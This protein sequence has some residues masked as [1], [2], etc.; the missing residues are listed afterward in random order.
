MHFAILGQTAVSAVKDVNLSAAQRRAVAALVAAGSQGMPADRLMGAI[1]EDD[2]DHTGPLKTLL[3][4]LR[5]LLG[6]RLPK[7]SAGSYRLDLDD[8]DTVDVTIFRALVEEAKAALEAGQR[9]RSV[10]ALQQALGLWGDP[11]LADVSTNVDRLNQWR[12]D[13]LLERQRA[14]LTLLQ[15]RL[16]LGEHHSLV[17]DVQRALSED[18]LSEPLY[19]ILMTA[20]FRAGRRAQALEQFEI[21]SATLF[22]HTGYGPGKDLQRLSEQIAADTPPAVTASPPA[23]A[24]AADTMAYPPAQLPAGVVDFTGR[25]QEIADLTAF[26]R[27]DGERPGVPIAVISGPPG[28]GKTELAIHVGHRLR[29]YFPCGQI[30]VNMAAMSDQPPVIAD[31]LAELLSMLGVAPR[32]LPPSTAQ[33]SSLVRSLLARRRML[34]VLDDVAAVH[35]VQPLF[36][37]AAGSAVILTS[38]IRLAGNGIR[39][40]RLEPLSAD[41]AR[42]LLTQIIGSERVAAEPE[43]T[44]E[45]LE[46]CSGLPLA[47]R[48]AGARLSI[49]DQ[50]RISHLAKRLSNRLPELTVDGW[51]VSA[52]VADSYH[53]LPDDARQAFRILSLAGPGDW[54]IWLATMLLGVDD[55]EPVL[56]T[57]VVHSLLTPTGVDALGQPRYR[58]HDLLREYGAMRL[59]EHERSTERDVT[60]ERLIMGWLELTDAADANVTRE[61]YFSPLR[62]MRGTFAPEQSFT[63]ISDD[64]DGWFAT[65]I[66]NVLSVIR[67]ASQQ[68]RHRLAY[69]LAMRASSYLVREERITDAEDMWRDVIQA[70]VAVSDVGIIANA[71]LR[72]ASLIIRQHGGPQRALPLMDTCITSLAQQSDRR[73]LAR[74]LA[75]RAACRY[76]IALEEQDAANEHETSYNP[77][78][79]LAA[80]DAQ[81]SLTLARMLTSSHAELISLRT[82]ALVASLRG[83]HDEA[84]S[85]GQ[86]AMAVSKT[87]CVE[88]GDGGYELFVLQALVTVLWAA[89]QCSRALQECERG[90]TLAQA[91][92][93]RLAEA[94]FLEQAGD[95]LTTMGHGTEALTHYHRAS[96]MYIGE[97]ADQHRLRCWN[98]L[99]AADVATR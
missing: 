46:V 7:G 61:P 68:Q 19:L 67:L 11:P 90:R 44:D 75:L 12:T 85:L 26:L 28:V 87:I 82:L 18:P 92:R 97:M 93:H 24:R 22:E 6:G 89:G 60:I 4:A 95:I 53:A 43:A 54:P 84:I 71:R 15:T 76:Q 30:W 48:I 49:Q 74:A 73:A 98:K 3:S 9:E 99:V 96:Q 59:A 91:L 77:Y 69:G 25:E 17:A 55:A 47:V 56:E 41:E 65:E 33:R 94:G 5:P 40:I 58:L 42:N 35:Q 79:E 37:G 39:P 29:N 32:D 51:D 14:T 31:V 86:Q 23:P 20:L 78:L 8:D 45:V 63:L 2:L 13:L 57:L 80:L 66:T 52:S 62:S 81:R 38:R 34:L 16:D 88:P 50:W 10:R 1:W 27:P 83:H 64:P 72:L 36:P 21:V 70:A